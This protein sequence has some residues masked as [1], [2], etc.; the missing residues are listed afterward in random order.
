MPKV[1]LTGV[2]V[3][4]LR[5]VPD[6]RGQVMHFLRASDPHFRKFG[7][8]YFSCIYPEVTKG[9]K[10][11][12]ASTSNLVVPEGRVKFVLFDTRENSSTRGQYQEVFLG[13]NHYV[14]LTIPPGIAYAWKNLLPT[15]AIV[16]NCATEEWSPDESKN[17]PFQEIPYAW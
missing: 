14:L 7:E 1:E 5:I 15:T 11:H 3:T 16:A 4:P 13:D 12:S 10:I 2:I 9:W 17:L 8:I 6:E